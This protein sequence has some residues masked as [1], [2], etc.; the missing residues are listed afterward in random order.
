MCCA[1]ST[2]KAANLRIPCQGWRGRAC[3]LVGVNFSAAIAFHDRFALL[4]IEVPY[5]T[6]PPIDHARARTGRCARPHV[7]NDRLR[8]ITSG[9]G[10]AFTPPATRYADADRPA[11]IARV[12]AGPN[13]LRPRPRKSAGRADLQ[14]EG[15]YAAGQIVDVLN[16]RVRLPASGTY[17]VNFGIA[18]PGGEFDR[19]CYVE[20]NAAIFFAR[21]GRETVRRLTDTSSP[22]LVT[23]S[24]TRSPATSSS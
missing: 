24:S 11:G 23:P 2:G 3:E 4:T 19:V 9:R 15:A 12:Y 21:D 18:D 6:E 7:A 1:R 14:R 8:R 13:E 16:L 10:D 20:G 5:A 17:D 22:A